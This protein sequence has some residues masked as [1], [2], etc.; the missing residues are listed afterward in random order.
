MIPTTIK[1]NEIGYSIKPNVP[2]SVIVRIS[3][4]LKSKKTRI[5]EKNVVK[6]TPLLNLLF[7]AF[8]LLDL[9]G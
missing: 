6:T 5:K 7:L 3:K 1:N 9:V 2:R 8:F 4:K